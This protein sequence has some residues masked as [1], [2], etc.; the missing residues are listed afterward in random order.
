MTTDVLTAEKY[1]SLDI[2]SHKRHT[3]L[4]SQ[5]VSS[6]QTKIPATMDNMSQSHITKRL[7]DLP[8]TISLR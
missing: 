3:S 8:S 6:L 2:P 5:K 4:M 7:P 1:F